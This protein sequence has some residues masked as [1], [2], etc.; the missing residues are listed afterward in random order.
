LRESVRDKLHN[1]KNDE[2]LMEHTQRLKLNGYFKKLLPTLPNTPVLDLRLLHRTTVCSSDMDAL[3]EK[4]ATTK[5]SKRF[6]IASF[7]GPPGCGKVGAML[8]LVI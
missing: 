4:I 6:H 3:Y 2:G 7:I 1:D 5:D 8:L